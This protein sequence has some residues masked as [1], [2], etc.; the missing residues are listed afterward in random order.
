[1]AQVYSMF[2]RMDK[3]T[4]IFSGMVTRGKFIF[5][6]FSPGDKADTR[7]TRFYPKNRVETGHWNSR[8]CRYLLLPFF[9]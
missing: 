3:N 5:N 2:S 1:M 8:A 6:I 7:T 4:K 9:Q